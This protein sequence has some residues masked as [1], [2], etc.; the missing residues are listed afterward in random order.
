MSWVELDLSVEQE[1][2]VNR[3]LQVATMAAPVRVGEEPVV[4]DARVFAAV[5]RAFG[6]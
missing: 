6:S 5:V 2:V 3:A 1:R 4:A